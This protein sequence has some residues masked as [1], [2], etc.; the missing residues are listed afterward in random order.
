MKDFFNNLLY[1]VLG[2]TIG[3]MITG[4]TISVPYSFAMG[5]SLLV[6]LLLRIV[7]TEID[8]R[9]NKKLL[10]K[11]SLLRNLVPIVGTTIGF[12]IWY[13]SAR[14]LAI[15]FFIIE[16]LSLSYDAFINYTKT[17]KP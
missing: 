14:F 5:V 9:G 10:I 7:L 12:I 13:Y 2:I 6:L 16:F 4:S 11:Y 3:V 15:T 1:M 8:T 17:L